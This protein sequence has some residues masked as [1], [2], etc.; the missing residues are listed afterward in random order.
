VNTQAIDS[1]VSSRQL[2]VFL[3]ILLRLSVLFTTVPLLSSKNFPGQFKI[4]LA[5]SMAYMLMPIVKFDLGDEHIASVVVKEVLLSIVMG[6]GVRFV[7]VSVNM[8]GQ[9]MS[10]AMGL[11]VASAFDPE[12][13]QSDEIA[14]LFG[15]IATLL[16]FAMD[17][18][19]ELIYMLVKSFDVVPPTSNINVNGLVVEAINIGS[20]AFVFALKLG[21]PVVVGMLVAHLMLGFIYKAAPQINIFFVSFPIFIYAGLLIIVL[22]LPLFISVVGG[23]YGGI[24]KMLDGILYIAKSGGKI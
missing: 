23:Y 22:S 10:N 14:R 9:V 24:G 15:I 19:H 5:M 6:L 16:F 1:I 8:A 20:R 11:S 21:A 7:F 13:G 18:H 4:G 17:A 2:T 3:L 12:F